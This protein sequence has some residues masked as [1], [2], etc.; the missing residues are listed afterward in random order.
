MYTYNNEVYQ[1]QA[2]KKSFPLNK[3]EKPSKKGN[4]RIE[5]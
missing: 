1:K 3:L 4:D 5:L 2:D